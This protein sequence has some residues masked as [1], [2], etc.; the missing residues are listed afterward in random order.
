MLHSVLRR[1]LALVVVT[2]GVAGAQSIPDDAGPISRSLV[3]RAPGIGVLLPIGENGALH[4]GLGA[5]GSV[6]SMSGGFGFPARSIVE[7]GLEAGY[8]RFSPAVDR[9]RTY[10]YGRVG[11]G[12]RRFKPDPAAPVHAATAALGFGALAQVTSRLG[13]MADV[14]AS[15]TVRQ[16]RQDVVLFPGEPF[17]NVSTTTNWGIVSSIGVTLRAKPSANSSPSP[18][19]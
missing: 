19:P 5:S 12:Q 1:F 16:Q 2:A 15:W 3:I 13:L 17:E 10:R 4:L 8:L 18:S 6:S 7:L 9:L 11:Y 14:G